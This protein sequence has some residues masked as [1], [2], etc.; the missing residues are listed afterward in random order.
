MAGALLLAANAAAGVSAN[1][2]WPENFPDPTIW[3]SSDGTW[4]ATASSQAKKTPQKIL[5]SRDFFQ[6][7]DSGRRVF[8]D[9]E[10][11]EIRKNW[12]EVWAPDAF[13]LGDEWLMYVTLYNSAADS[14]IAVFSSKDARG[15]FTDGRIVTRSS[16]TGIKDTIDPEAVRDDRDGTLWL[17]FGS[18][19]KMHRVKLSDDGKSVAP[20]AVYEHVAG[21]DSSTVSNR[22]QVFEGAY[23]KRRGG[24]WYLFAS[25]GWYKN[26]TYG[27][28]VGRA[29]TLDGP[30]L[31][32]EGRRM[33]DGFGTTVIESQKG[34]RF[35]GPGHN[36]DI[37]T[38][39]G[40]DYIPY[41]CH[42]A[43][44]NPSAR[45]LF[46]S[47]LVWDEGGWPHATLPVPASSARMAATAMERLPPGSV[48]PQGWL[49]KQMELQLGGLTG[50]AEELY[51]DIGKSDWLTGCK[52]G[53]Q[54][55][56]ERGPYYAKG[57]VALA[58]A[59]DDETLKARAKRWI[60]AY[61][62][63]QR[64]NGD[65]GPKDCNWWANMIALWTLRDWCEATEDER[66]VPF[67]ERYFAF[68][69]GAFTDGASFA[70]DSPWAVARVGDELDVLLWLWRKTLKT[71]W[72]DYA[73]TVAEM[74]ADWTDYYHNGGTGGWGNEGYRA[75]IVNFMQGLKTP[76]LKWLLGGGDADRTAFRA[77]LAEDGWAMRK[78]GRPDRAVN[79]TEPLS[80][81]SAS[82]G[83]ELC[84][85]A[86]HILSA[87]VALET[88][89]DADIADDMEIAAYNTLPATLAPDGRGMRYYCLL[90][91]PCCIDGK[92]L[93]NNGQGK[94]PNVPGPYSGF[95][96]CRSNFHFAWPKFLESMWM[97][98]EDGLAATA[99]GDCIVKTP[100][101]TI[102]E[103]GGYPFSDGV[104]LEIV[105]AAGGEW[106]L[107]V[108]IPGW[109]KDA[110]VKVNGADGGC[111]RAGSFMRLARK[112]KKGD[113]VE[114]SFPS[115]PTV[116]HWKD[117]SIAVM[118]GPLLYALKI[119][120]DEKARNAA[121]WPAVK[122]DASD[123]L[124]DVELGFPM[125]ELRPKSPWNYALVADGATGEP[126]F[127]VKGEG[128]GLRL[129]VKAVRTG[130]AGWGTM[131]A[132][133]PARAEDPPPSPVPAAAV[134]GK[135]ETIEL[136]PIALTQLRITLFPWIK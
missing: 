61:L 88:L 56:W 128:L 112:W 22:L 26:Y 65:F 47:E 121:D 64:E 37:V 48:R 85:T 55:A 70:K 13:R 97:K 95:G 87:Q 10:Y 35:F 3:Q 92:L 34:D 77:A 36:G 132:D 31:D 98:R 46:V 68:Q 126:Q 93:Y 41:H 75:H 84:A 79:G 73:R 20:G 57:L 11:A 28:V 63:S 82:Q 51:E 108:R 15:P 78:H 116:T 30:F 49:L 66:V 134:Q 125:K 12:K 130:Y 54:F 117:D 114:L 42:I 16:D 67:L 120:E 40:K 109:C 123:V 6:W 1:P 127:H 38:I 50:H 9:D 115:K 101:A 83:T 44:K 8:A 96:C 110:K 7:E 103:T 24:W 133:A 59:L 5:E 45:P 18:I 74:S 106:P 43:G 58:F 104:R 99:Y 111:A 136:A 2:V 124:R 39:D 29:R 14:A 91:Q 25:R 131:R 33:I 21:L 129:A 102:A 4:L 89:G 71:E 118:R 80:G 62:A 76:P 23:L 100:I 86:E 53:G 27:V 19:G 81:L 72:L 17:F 60:D 119:D 113:V 90:N 32:R 122:K 69:R 135:A 52:R 107:F 105:E 94:V